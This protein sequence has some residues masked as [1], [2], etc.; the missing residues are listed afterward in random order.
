[1]KP[2]DLP[3]RNIIFAEDQP[4]YQNLPAIVMPIPGGNEVISCW[5][6]SE[7]EIAA[8]TKNRCLYIS[9]LCFPTLNEKGILVNNPLQPILPMAELGDN[10]SFTV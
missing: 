5:E 8:I 7:E 10:I 9:Q 1:M 2:I 6:L 3:G 4:E